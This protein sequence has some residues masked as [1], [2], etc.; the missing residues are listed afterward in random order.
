MNSQVREGF[1]GGR[2]SRSSG[3]RGLSCVS[4]SRIKG[5]QGFKKGLLS[6][7]DDLEGVSKALNT[8]RSGFYPFGRDCADAFCT[9]ACGFRL[10]V[11]P[12]FSANLDSNLRVFLGAG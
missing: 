6:F 5:L 9:D 7:Q 11:C 3:C 1:R 12:L 8:G 10:R 2:E 4:G